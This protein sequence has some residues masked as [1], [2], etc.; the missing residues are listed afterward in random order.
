[1]SDLPAHYP[2]VPAPSPGLS[3]HVACSDGGDGWTVVALPLAAVAAAATHL[4]AAAAAATV[5]SI[6]P[7][8]PIFRRAHR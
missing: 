6:V 4:A 1:M 3:F 8:P 2:S 5:R 7:P